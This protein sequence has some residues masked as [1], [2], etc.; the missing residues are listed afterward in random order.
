MVIADLDPELLNMCTGRRWI[1][2]RRPELYGLLA[3]STGREED[4]RKVRFE[5]Q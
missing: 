3:R 5:R 4:T 2:T 1:K